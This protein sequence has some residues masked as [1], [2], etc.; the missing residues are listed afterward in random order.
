M[1]ESNG[2]FK[3]KNV[4]IH[5]TSKHKIFFTHYTYQGKNKKHKDHLNSNFSR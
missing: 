4:L 3:K 5:G 1:L 2:N